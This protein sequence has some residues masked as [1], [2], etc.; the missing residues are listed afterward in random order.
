[1]MMPIRK[2]LTGQTR[3]PIDAC[4]SSY[5]L[6][7]FLLVAVISQAGSNLVLAAQPQETIRTESTLPEDELVLR[8]IRAAHTI[9]LIRAQ[10]SQIID[11]KLANIDRAS[12]NGID[13]L[14]DL[15][16][17][18]DLLDQASLSLKSWTVAEVALRLHY[19]HITPQNTAKQI[20]K[21]SKG[22]QVRMAQLKVFA[23]NLLG[24]EL[25]ATAKGRE[26]RNT[27]KQAGELLLLEVLFLK[28][29]ELSQERKRL[30][31][32]AKQ[33]TDETGSLEA[34]DNKH[35]DLYKAFKIRKRKPPR[36][37]AAR[38][39]RD[40]SKRPGRLGDTKADRQ[41]RVLLVCA[42]A[43]IVV[44]GILLY[45]AMSRRRNRK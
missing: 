11:A 22:F 30:F 10:L 5:C 45:F 12:A 3:R 43:G 38:K 7:S 28:D 13:S 21:R 36:Q 44:A 41:L 34:F 42:G 29:T 20:L 39:P 18:A 9:N 19:K 26:I 14:R 35:S 8:L 37:D 16:R 23:I 32:Q 31:E 1:M 40:G 2:Y 24:A 27:L 33:Y 4:A 15:T 6:S 17:Y 25:T